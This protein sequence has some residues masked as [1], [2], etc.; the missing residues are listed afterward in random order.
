MSKVYEVITDKIIETMEKGTI[1]WKKPWSGGSSMGSC[2][3]LITG[4]PY[5]GINAL[6]TAMIGYDSP[7]F[8]TY[9]QAQSIGGNVKK[10]EKGIPIVFWNFIE[11]EK[12]NGET[13]TMAFCKYYTVFNYEQIENVELKALEGE[14][15]KERE[16][17]TIDACE[18]IL[19]GMS[20]K[21][22]IQFETQRAY[23]RPSADLVLNKA[24]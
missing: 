17:Q 18:M 6:I 21:P 1:P 24:K 22:K 15:R 7:Y 3:N 4:K 20:E 2:K 14:Q 16:F 12:S 5:R 8:L 10:G 13:D 19:S 23:Y 9:K 11:K